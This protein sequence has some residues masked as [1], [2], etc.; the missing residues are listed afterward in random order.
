MSTPVPL[1]PS[2]DERERA[3]E[4]LQRACGDGRL[5]LEEFSVRVGAV[6]AANSG[7]ELE[8]ATSGLAITPIVGS[9]QTIDSVT[10]IFSES[11]RRGRWRLRS[12]RLWLRTFFGQTTLDLR[13][14]LTS[15]PT[16]EIGGLCL[17]GQVTVIVPEGVEVDLSG[18]VVFAN[19]DLRLAPVPRVPG[20]PEIRVDIATWFGQVHVRSKRSL[21]SQ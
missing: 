21:P 7:Q 20:T 10:T 13:E 11:K 15:E 5:T 4:L 16:I 18:A 6:W 12:S 9:A 2:D 19:H 14:V 17:F 8:L 3:A 1:P